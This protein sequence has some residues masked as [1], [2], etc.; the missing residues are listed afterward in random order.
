[1]LPAEN[2]LKETARALGNIFEIAVPGEIR[3]VKNT[4][5]YEALKKLLA[6]RLGDL[7]NNDF[8][9]FVNTLYRIDI[10]EQK[11][12]KI[13]AEHPFEEVKIMISEMII[14]RQLQKIIT[15]KQYSASRD[16]LQFD[17]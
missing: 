16:D 12:K 6:D 7:I 5:Q 8:D 2:Y 13:I 3:E 1:M 10:D 17:I 14:Q 4:V 11:V 9:T 15:R